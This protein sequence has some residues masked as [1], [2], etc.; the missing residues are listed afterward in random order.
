LQI[1]K[2]HPTTHFFGTHKKRDMAHKKVHLKLTAAQHR[3]L[4]KALGGRGLGD[5]HA[6]EDIQLFVEPGH[7]GG[8]GFLSDLG[9]EVKKIQKSGLVRGL[10]KKAV[11]YGA[12]ALRGAAEGTLDGIGDT[13]ATAIGIPEVAPA[14]DGM[15]DRGASALQKRGIEYLD[16]KIDQ[17]GKGMRYMA[18]GGGMR[19]AGT[20]T[21]SGSGMRLSGQGHCGKS[22]QCGCGMRLSGRGISAAQT[23]P[24]YPVERGMG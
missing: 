21:L 17:S 2:Q 11:N 7:F 24:A 8:N 4:V 6:L 3:D 1:R 9:S 16:D 22:D 19:M 15:I 14:L 5:V 23:F 13:M 18:S 12:K 20:H 10:E